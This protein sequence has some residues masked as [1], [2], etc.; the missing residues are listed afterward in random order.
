[1]LERSIRVRVWVCQ[2]F[3][4]GCIFVWIALAFACS[5]PMP[6]DRSSQEASIDQAQERTFAMQHKKMI[7]RQIEARGV[8]DP[9]VLAAL[10]AVERHRFVPDGERAYSYE[11]RPLPIGEG[12]TISQPYIVG[13]MTELLDPKRT[14]KVLEIGTGSGYQAAVLGEIVRDVYTIEIVE[15]LGRRSRALLKLLG[16]KNIHVRIGDGFQGWPEEAPF[17]KI[18]VTAAPEEVPQPLIDQ[19]AVGG[20]LVIPVGPPS[21]QRLRILE[22]RPDG[23]VTRTSIAVRF[24]LM[25][26]EAMEQ[27]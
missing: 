14:D 24:V 8:R 16:Y 27:R 25:T 11:D 2:P 1:M 13:L 6:R 10:R 18:I 7:E 20:I 5:E 17:D 12:Q 3:V 9:L 15:D 21:S 22:R 23:V 4:R 26:G 19:L